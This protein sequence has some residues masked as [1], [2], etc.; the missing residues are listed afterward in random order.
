VSEEITRQ[1][2]EAAHAHQ[3]DRERMLA[4][5]ERGMAGPA[6]RHRS[7]SF[8]RSGPRTAF[9][10]L[11]AAVLLATGGLAVAAIVHGPSPSNTVL[12]P[13]GHPTTTPGPTPS[14]TAVASA[15]PTTGPANSPRPTRSVIVP[16][17]Q[18]PL[19]AEGSVDPHSTAYWSQSNLVLKSG[20]PLDSFTLELS[21]AQTGG[22]RSTGYWSTLPSQDFTVTVQ[23]DGGLLVYRWVLKPGRTIP[24]GQYEFAVQYNHAAGD[25]DSGGDSYQGEAQTPGG[26]PAEVTGGF[27]LLR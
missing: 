1:L 8:I 19:S 24:A 7:P 23:P 3:P 15:P 20:R 27:A 16:V 2:H 4:R 14:D 6:V 17:G 18:G 11:A 26:S 21:I 12:A 10:A 13:T 22:V 5:V 25:R 9:A